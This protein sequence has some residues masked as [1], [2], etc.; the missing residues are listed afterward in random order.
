[1]LLQTSL[2]KTAFSNRTW[3]GAI[4]PSPFELMGWF[5]CL[6]AAI[7]AG[8][9]RAATVPAY[10]LELDITTSAVNL[11]ALDLADP[12]NPASN[13]IASSTVNRNWGNLMQDDSGNVLAMDGN[14]SLRRINSSGGGDTNLG[15]TGIKNSS[16]G[17]F[18]GDNALISNFGSDTTGPFGPTIYALN[19][20]SP[21][22]PQAIVT[23][24]QNIGNVQAMAL[25]NA[26]DVDQGG[27]DQGDVVVVANRAPDGAFNASR[28]LYTVNLNTGFATHIGNLGGTINDL[29][30]G[31][32]LAMMENFTVSAATGRLPESMRATPRK[33]SSGLRR[34]LSAA[35]TTGSD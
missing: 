2:Y 15:F 13:F 12:T 11:W 25:A 30:S 14:G 9:T 1:M 18:R 27:T 3:A 8:T 16:G 29:M 10:G 34:D 19:P 7:A 5:A 28:E 21:G 31:L 22:S 32:I 24:P 33:P 35:P 6:A 23:V 4:L 26:G 17:D 20:A